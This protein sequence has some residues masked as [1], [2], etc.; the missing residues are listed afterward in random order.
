MPY[1]KHR[2][3]TAAALIKG[4]TRLERLF[5]GQK[6]EKT[7]QERRTQGYICTLRIKDP[8]LLDKFRQNQ[9]Q[10]QIAI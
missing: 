4:G 9:C 7:Y 3:S 8:S 2:F 6:N 1:E 5:V 10:A